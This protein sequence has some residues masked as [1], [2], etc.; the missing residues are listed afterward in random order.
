MH[1][2]TYFSGCDSFSA[3]VY[4]L[5]ALYSELLSRT[6]AGLFLALKVTEVGEC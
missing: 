3:T 5:Y 6:G 2:S 1:H 4:V